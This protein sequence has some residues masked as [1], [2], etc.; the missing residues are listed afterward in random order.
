ME[1]Y[2]E[3]I[4]VV[5]NALVVG[6]SGGIG[7]PGPLLLLTLTELFMDIVLSWHP[8]WLNTAIN[9][10]LLN[11]WVQHQHLLFLLHYFIFQQFIND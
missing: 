10:L 2:F 7:C 11:V 8:H 3:T 5:N 4:V 1:D 9:T 6:G